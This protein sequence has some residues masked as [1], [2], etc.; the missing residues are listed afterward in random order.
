LPGIFDGEHIFEI[1]KCSSSSVTLV[2]RENFSGLLVSLLWAS[3][4]ENTE[5]GF[6]AMNEALK[7]RAESN[8]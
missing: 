7:L 5:K 3:I 2:Q 8:V 4:A 1:S 6:L